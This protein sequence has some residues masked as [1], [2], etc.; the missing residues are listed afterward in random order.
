MT[1]QT[2]ATV[3]VDACQLRVGD[4]VSMCQ[5]SET[6]DPGFYEVAVAE[7]TPQGGCVAF[8]IGFKREDGTVNFIPTPGWYENGIYS[9]GSRFWATPEDAAEI[10]ARVDLFRE[11]YPDE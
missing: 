6:F 1:A 10:N 11:V 2:T 7:Y 3:A 4:R 5:A 8:R 9:W